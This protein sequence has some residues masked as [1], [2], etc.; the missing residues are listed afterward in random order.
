[1][2]GLLALAVAYVLSQFYRSFLAVLT[3]QLT[4]DLGADKADL[5]LASGLWFVCFAFMQFMV[6]VGLDR[7]GPRRTSAWLFGIFATAG[8]FVFASAESPNAVVLAMCLIG[9]GCS[10][11][12]M[13]SLFIFAQRFDSRQFA[14]MT[15]WL[16]AVGT[17][18]NVVGAS[19]LAS[20]AEIYG[21][22]G[23]MAGLGILSF[24]VAAAMYV[25]IRD[26]EVD[27]PSSAGL[28]GYLTLLKSPALWAIMFMSLFCYAPVAGIRGLWAGPYLSDLYN[29]DSLQIGQVTL[30]MAIAMIAGS[31]VYGP[32]DKVFNTRK[33]VI[34]TGNLMVLFALLYFAIQPVPGIGMSSM[35][36]IVIG[37]CGTSYGVLMAHGRAFLPAHLVGRGVTLLNFCA[38][39]GAGVMQFITGRIV[40]VQPDTGSP[41]TYQILFAVYAACLLLGLGVYLTSKDAPP[42]GIRT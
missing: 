41:V 26:P 1:M 5:S 14:I 30:W 19:P 23:V 29:S 31:L 27:A 9:I 8:A 13:A 20:A 3:P 40:S 34:F 36:F 39:F 35:L 28:G 2:P 32:L 12:L 22:R 37:V 33:W 38:I 25:L 10:P 16:V 7:F 42:A 11:V 21:W 18:G 17:L 24:T 15:S 6:G 4:A